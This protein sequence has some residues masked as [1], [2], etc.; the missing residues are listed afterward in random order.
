MP[1]SRTMRRVRMAGMALCL[2]LLAPALLHAQGRI[3]GKVVNGTTGR[4]LA[5]QKV[6]LLTPKPGEGMQLIADTTTDSSG[7]FAFAQN[8]IGPSAFFLLQAN[9]EQI[10]Y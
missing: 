10:P 9:V 6:L 3:E 2:C 4:P 5:N 7:H 8:G 1:Q